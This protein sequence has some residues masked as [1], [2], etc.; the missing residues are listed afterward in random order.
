M[1]QN[2]A[3]LRPHRPG[4]IGYD[5]ETDRKRPGRVPSALLSTVNDYSYACTFSAKT[6]LLGEQAR[7]SRV[8]TVELIATVLGSYHIPNRHMLWRGPG[9]ALRVAFTSGPSS[10]LQR[11]PQRKGVMWSLS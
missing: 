4:P 7:A 8:E 1:Y 2:N 3:I 10:T 6:G 5:T 11:V 9:R